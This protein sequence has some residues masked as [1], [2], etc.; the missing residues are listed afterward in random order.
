MV[1]SPAMIRRRSSLEFAR[2]GLKI[3][4]TTGTK[5]MLS[6]AQSMMAYASNANECFEESLAYYEAAIQAFDDSGQ[7]LKA[8]RNRLGLMMALSM[9]GDLRRRST[10]AIGQ[11]AAFLRH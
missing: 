8:A 4:E 10:S 5:E 9:L 1:G 3:A 11:K 7:D 2:L 6:E